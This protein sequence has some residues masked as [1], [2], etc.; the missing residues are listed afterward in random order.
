MS[1]HR[2][3]Q[4]D[5][6]TSNVFAGNPAGVCRLDDWL[7]DATLIQIA[8]ENCLSETAFYVPRTN[9]FDLRWFTP[10]TEVDLCGH[11]TLATAF[12]LYELEGFKG[13]RLQF[14]TRS[15]L[16]EV[17]RHKDSFAMLFPSREGVPVSADS[18]LLNAIKPAVPTEVLKAR[19]LMLV[20]QNEQEVKDFKP[21]MVLLAQL[22]TFGVIVT[23]PGNQCDFVSRFFAPAQGIPEDPVTGS[24]HCTL[25]PYWS[26]RL[27][28]LD[29]S[30]RQISSRGGEIFCQ[31][32]GGHVILTGKAQLYL[33]GF[34]HV[35]G[36]S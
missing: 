32:R 24:A 35:P 34:I 13:P 9:G 36:E 11:A 21:D 19:D 2:F 3:Y 15:G 12:V 16:L 17:T 8:A 27:G 5:A 29:L 23:A 28:K 20:M 31:Y 4:I 30:A 10:E 33:D 6:F 22:N 14:H 25:T 1:R 26:Q 7:N 18:A